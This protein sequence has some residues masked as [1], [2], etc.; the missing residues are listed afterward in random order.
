MF[1]VIQH[2][3]LFSIK[4]NC[5]SDVKRQNMGSMEVRVIVCFG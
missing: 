4:S 1:V 3:V 2:V 5:F